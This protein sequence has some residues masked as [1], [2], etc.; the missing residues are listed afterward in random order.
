MT[1]KEAFDTIR[2]MAQGIEGINPDGTAA[3]AMNEASYL[4]SVLAS[5]YKNIWGVKAGTSWDGETILMPTWEE[6]DGKTVQTKAYFR[7]YPDWKAAIQDY[8]SL[9]RRLYPFAAKY[10]SN[11]VAF[12]AGL[13]QTGP[14]KW[15]TDSGAF[16]KALSI[17]ESYGSVAP[18][19][20]SLKLGEHAVVVDNS[21]TLGKGMAII[22]AALT[23]KPAVL[24]GRILATRTR[25]ADGSYKLDL[26]DL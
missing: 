12:L 14:A 22:S 17:L 6:V 11:P 9:I 24:N 8:A 16:A 5:E 19:Q 2:N 21:P 20:D 1:N 18:V 10:A 15:A 4:R 7:V 23:R 13:F 26:R 25:R 3:H